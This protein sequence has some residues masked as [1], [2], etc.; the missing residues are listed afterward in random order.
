MS[1]AADGGCRP[2]YKKSNT[3][4][5]MKSKLLVLASM[6]IASGMMMAQE[7]AKEGKGGKGGKGGHCPNPE[8][9]F[10]KLDANSDSALSLDELK[11]CPH[12]QEHPEKVAER[13]AK[14]DANSDGKVTLDE[15]KAG[16][17]PHCGDKGKPGKGKHGKGEKGGQEA[18][19]AGAPAGGAAA[20]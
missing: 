3:S 8:E 14:L 9:M 2:I 7:P 17:P 15:F 5:I 20:E 4:K 10:K 12:A 6:V 13:F 19:P 1:I 16:R 11:A 18:P